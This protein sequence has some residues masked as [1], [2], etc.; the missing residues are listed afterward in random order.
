MA[1]S[2]DVQLDERGIV[3][4][5]AS[6]GTRNRLSYERL[7][8]PTRCGQ[9]KITLS[10]PGFPI[11]IPTSGDFDRIVSRS[12]IPVVVDYWAPWCGPCR[13]VA[14]ELAKVAAR[15]Q[16]RLLVV[17]VNSDELHDLGERFNIRS[18]PTMAV[19]A[20]GREVARTTGARPAA[21]IEAFLERATA[22]AAR[23]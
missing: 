20:G 2:Q 13:M 6:C 9:C 22:G 21:E 17:K 1:P 18:I 4:A 11:D 23:T 8:Q 3:V 14:P 10:P 7:G 12:A 19:F 16:G 5:C 15:A